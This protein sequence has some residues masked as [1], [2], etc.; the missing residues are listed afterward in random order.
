MIKGVSVKKLNF[1]CDERGRLMEILRKDDAIFEK[2]GQVYITT[3]YP[4]VVKAWHLHKKQ[5]DF[6]TC[7]KGMIKLVL[8]DGRE[9]S[10]TFKEVDEF[11]VGDFN[12]VL[13]KIPKG[14]W[15]GFKCVSKDEAILV[16][17]PTEKYNRKRPDE[18]RLP[19]DTKKIPYDWDVKM[20]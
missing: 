2:F 18:F 19:F 15:H 10:K 1:I 12:P 3:A 14:V 9:N 4:N 8:F 16:N 11:F 6:I 17:I 20:K 7:I 5:D 13:V